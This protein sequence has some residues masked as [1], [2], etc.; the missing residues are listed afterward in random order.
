MKKLIAL[1]LIL[2]LPS[3]APAE[4]GPAAALD[5]VYPDAI[6]LSAAQMDDAA[7]YALD[8]PGNLPDKLVGFT[9]KGGRWALTLDSDT[10]L[11]PS[12]LSDEYQ[13]YLYDW[14]DL[15]LDGGVLSIRY[16]RGSA[17]WWQYE[18]ARTRDGWRFVRLY[19]ADEVNQRYDELTY[20]DGCVQQTFTRGSRQGKWEVEHFPPCPTPWLSGCETL[21]GFDAS[22]FPMDLN[23]LGYDEL[24]RVAHELLPGYTFLDGK[25]STRAA[26]TFLMENPAGDT[27]FLGGVY[28]DGW[29]WTESTPLPEGTGCDS[30]HAGAGSMMIYYPLPETA[31]LPAD[32]QT[33][34][35][36]VIDLQDDG[37][38]RVTGLLNDR[39]DW[40]SFND[41]FLYITLSGPV[42]GDC[43]LERDITKIDWAAYPTSIVDVLPCITDDAGVVGGKV[44]PLYADA[45]GGEILWEYQPGTPVIIL[46]R[47]ETRVQVR[48]A[49]SEITGWMDPAGLLLGGDQVIVEEEPDPEGFHWAYFYTAEVCA[50]QAILDRDGDGREEWYQ[51]LSDQGDRYHVFDPDGPES[52]FVPAGGCRLSAPYMTGELGVDSLFA[53]E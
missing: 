5:A 43:T 27:V 14:I 13:R 50:P 46:D 21:S 9:W 36:Y 52:F 29:V 48:I 42:W 40:I 26:A 7:F 6:V 39:E 1:L 51:L 17:E 34:I 22:A 49:D 53:E 19:H 31:H 16:Q 2:F 23:G 4:G 37:T 10:A 45:E 20:R 35:Q 32:E 25:F 47:A 8:M 41:G 30:Y 38:W 44:Q 3:A 12:G 18:F 28:E 33:W 24:S 11:R 15:A